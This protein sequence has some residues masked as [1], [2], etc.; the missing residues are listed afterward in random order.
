MYRHVETYIH[1]FSTWWLHPYW[2][3]YSGVQRDMLIY[4]SRGSGIWYSSV[5]EALFLNNLFQ[6]R[7]KFL[8]SQELNKRT[9][10]LLQISDQHQLLLMNE[11]WILHFQSRIHTSG[12]SLA[13]VGFAHREY[14][15]FFQKITESL[16]SSLFTKCS[17]RIS[18]RPLPQSL[19]F[20]SMSQPVLEKQHK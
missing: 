7:N 4:L 19:E 11:V 1:Y 10:A 14:P 9:V 5:W 8:V 13:T 2:H 3:Y 20:R 6:G 18:W 15:Y 12:L 17:K 16:P